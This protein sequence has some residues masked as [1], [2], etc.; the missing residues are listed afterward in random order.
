MAL[1][2]NIPHSDNLLCSSPVC[3]AKADVIV[4]LKDNIELPYCTEHFM[5]A[6]ANENFKHQ[7]RMEKLRVAGERNK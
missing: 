3:Q 2:F 1:L 7:K 4:H 5:V 6:S